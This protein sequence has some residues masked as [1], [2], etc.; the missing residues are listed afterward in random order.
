MN[1][2]S[3]L[4][5]L[6][7]AVRSTRNH[8]SLA[9]TQE[10]PSVIEPELPNI[11]HSLLSRAIPSP[12]RSPGRA[13]GCCESAAA[14][15]AH[16]TAKKRIFVGKPQRPTFVRRFLENAGWIVPG[17]VLALLPKCPACVATYAVIGAGVGFS[18][19]GMTY[20]RVLLAIVCTVSLLYV[21]V[22]RMRPFIATILAA[23]RSKSC[24]QAERPWTNPW[25][26]HCNRWADH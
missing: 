17:T 14:G 13:N 18:L 5:H 23:Q 6:L 4:F 10:L 11:D 2:D 3:G 7:M 19:P 22:R 9:Q 20:L 26:R 12:D 25:V 24:E 8:A 16:E 21:A 15:L 1:T